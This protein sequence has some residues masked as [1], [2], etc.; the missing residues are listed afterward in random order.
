MGD[1]KGVQENRERGGMRI[2]EDIIE[3]E[4]ERE[5]ERETVSSN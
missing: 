3:R 2:K 4:R 5:R 1:R